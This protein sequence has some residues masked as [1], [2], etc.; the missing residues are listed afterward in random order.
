MRF[1]YRQ[2][3]HGNSREIFRQVRDF[4]VVKK[5]VIGKA[6]IDGFSKKTVP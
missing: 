4:Y 6:M 2:P 5:V 3:A 1:I